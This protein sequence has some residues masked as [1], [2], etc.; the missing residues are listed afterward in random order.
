MRRLR[1]QLSN[2]PNLRG[3]GAIVGFLV[4]CAFVAA[5]LLSL[6]GKDDGAMAFVTWG[7]PTL[8]AGLIGGWLLAP[9]AARASTR[10]EWLGVVLRLGVVAVIVGAIGV[11]IGMGIDSALRGDAELGQVILS[12]VVGALMLAPLGM[13]VMGWMILPLTTLAAG[14]WALVMA[15]LLRRAPA[16]AR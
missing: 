3:Q 14:I 5:G 2:V 13:L 4:A 10:R 9:R 12:T 11:G 8:L 16:R 1:L 6:L 15:R 7:I